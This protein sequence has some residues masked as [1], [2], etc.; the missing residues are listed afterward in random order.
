[1]TYYGRWTYK[2]EEAVR[3]GAA[4]L[5]VIH[6]TGPA[7]YPWEVPRNGAA[8][9]Q[10]DLRIA[11]YEHA[12]AGARGLDHARGDDARARAGRAGLR[13]AQARGGAARL[14]GASARPH[15]ERRRAQRRERA[16]ARTTSSGCCP[17]RERPDEA[18]VYTAHWDH[19]G[20]A[21][22]RG[23]GDTIYNGAADNATGV[24]R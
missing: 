6:E 22:L 1:M 12:A 23:D 18:F 20:T 3:Q 14:P 5:L 10:F 2:F 9:P 21:R 19:L 16:H 24:P 8:K 13:H 17:G 11:D 15:R 4:G 7:G